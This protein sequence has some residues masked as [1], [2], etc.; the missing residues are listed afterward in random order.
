MERRPGTEEPQVPSPDQ[1]ADID[2]LAG[3]I[4]E[5]L[6]KDLATEAQAR[7][8]RL[9][10]PDQADVFS[11]LRPELLSMLL[12]LLTNESVGLVI[13][14]IEPEAAA[15]IL[16][17]M[18]ADRLPSVLDEAS[19]DVAA[20]LLRA[21]PREVG[22]QVLD[23]MSEAAE[24]APLLAYE[25]DDAGGLMTSDFVALYDDMSVNQAT[26]FV[27]RWARDLAPQDVSYLFVVDRSGMLKG[28]ISLAELVLAQPP[29]RVS[30]LMQ[31]DVFSVGTETDQEQCARLMERYNL[32]SL[33]VVDEA[34]A[35][36]GVLKLE[37][38]LGVLQDEA[39]EDMYRMIGIY[40]EEKALGPFWRSVRGRLPWL[41]VNLATAVMAGIVVILF[42]STLQRAVI[43]AAFLPIVAGQAGIAGTQTLTVIV[44]SIALG[45]VTGANT[46]RLLTKEVGL[47]LVHGLAIAV[48]V[49]AVAVAWTKSGYLGLVV[50]VAMMLNLVVSSVSGV[51]V[52]MGFKAIRVDP[53][54]SS[55]VA[56]TATTDIVGFLVFLGLAAAAIGP[57]ERT[58]G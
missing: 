50:A 35:L 20:D 38:M 12:D 57:I 46:M 47:G 43:L 27:R 6:E 39:T 55:A 56:V 15:E 34:G 29:Q 30:L 32:Q 52:P 26:A 4:I 49:G 13:E 11:V 5:L 7:F 2:Q 16:L 28:G 9:R 21:L 22:T 48:V 24:V 31:T 51:L 3:P 10:P 54:H 37:D 33:P 36:V 53:A 42:E 19:P 1:A 23:G 58:L 44:R 17:L 14:E 40:E 18:R 45:E 41:I 8:M 25:D